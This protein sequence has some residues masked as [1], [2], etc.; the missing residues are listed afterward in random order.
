MS[1]L[2]HQHNQE[3]RQI[4]QNVPDDRG[5]PAFSALDLIGCHEKPG[6]VQKQINSGEAKQMDGTLANT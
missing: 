6:P 3:Q 1:E 2:M 4:L 5:I